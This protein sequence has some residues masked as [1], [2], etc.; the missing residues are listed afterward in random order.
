MPLGDFEREV[1]RTLAAGRNPDSFVGGGTVLHQA[2]DS[3]RRSED[4]DLF[5]D[6]V[7]S[8]EAAFNADTAAL[9][10]AG[11]GIE[12]VG[13]VYP[14]FRRAIVHRGDLQTKLEWV[15]DSAF[16]FFPVERDLELGWRLN[17]WDAATNKVL[18]LVGRQKIRDYLDCLYLHERHLHLGA[19]AWAAGG[20]DPGMT[21]DLIVDWAARGNRFRSEDLAEVRL[22]QPVDLRAAKQVWLEA[23][24]QARALIEKLPMDEMG[25]L[26]LDAASQPVCPDP[27]SAEFPKLTRHFGSIK[28]AWPRIAE[29]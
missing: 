21:P 24:A 27:G 3:P 17:F 15:H 22:S 12:L 19:L 11:F 4:V 10:A 8:L 13:N 28:G 1:M 7:A 6:T 25:C 26:Y 20:K 23:I 2:A 14:E 16:R 5:H 29:S 9:R 18:A